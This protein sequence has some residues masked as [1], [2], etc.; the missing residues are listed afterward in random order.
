VA[1][2]SRR[3]YVLDTSVLLSDPHALLR[4]DE[5]E[6]VLPVVVPI[7][8]AMR[9]GTEAYLAQL[10]YLEIL[11]VGVGLRRGPAA[12]RK[13]KRVR[14]VLKERGSESEPHPVMPSA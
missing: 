5:H 3:T 6:V 14:Q 11:M 13:L 1:A 4:F 8:R 2:P 12:F 10:T 7:D 9:V